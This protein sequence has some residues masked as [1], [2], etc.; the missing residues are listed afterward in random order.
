MY[1]AT[2]LLFCDLFVLIF[3]WLLVYWFWL[4]GWFSCLLITV[5]LCIWCMLLCCLGWFVLVLSE[6]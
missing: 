2:L 3:G 6:V 5:D 4:D 1:F